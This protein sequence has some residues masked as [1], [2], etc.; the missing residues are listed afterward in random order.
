VICITHLPQIAAFAHH[1]LRIEKQVTDGRTKTTIEP[2]TEDQ[3]ITEIARMLGGI[4]ITQA[5]LDHAREMV[6]NR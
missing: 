5:T 4:T 3:R 1:H 2:V 6:K